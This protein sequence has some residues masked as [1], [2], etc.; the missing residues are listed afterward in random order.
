MKLISPSNKEVDIG[1]TLLPDEWIGM[2]RR[3]VLDTYLRDRAISLGATAINGLVTEVTI[4]STKDG[5]SHTFCAGPDTLLLIIQSCRC[6][7]YHLHVQGNICPFLIA[8]DA[9]AHSSL[10]W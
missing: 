5:T 2:V 10:R 1:D 7:C 4:P 3:E 8:L 6:V 9:Q